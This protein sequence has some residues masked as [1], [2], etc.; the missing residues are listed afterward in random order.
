MYVSRSVV[1]T[2]R[3][4]SLI[5]P[6]EKKINLKQK[7][8]SRTHVGIAAKKIT[9]GRERPRQMSCQCTQ[10]PHQSMSNS[11]THIHKSRHTQTESH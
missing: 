8:R 4:H 6:Q 3:N 5:E 1:F 10:G 7:E 9:E 11:Q 2:F